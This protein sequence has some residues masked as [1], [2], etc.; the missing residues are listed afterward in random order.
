MGFRGGSRWEEEI[1]CGGSEVID[2]F[3]VGGCAGEDDFAGEEVGVDEG[4]G[5][6]WRGEDAGDGGFTGCDVAG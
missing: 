3:A 1:G 5:V 6:G 2:D 4:E